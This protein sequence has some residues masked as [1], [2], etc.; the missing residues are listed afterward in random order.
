MQKRL[1]TLLVLSSIA[2][3]TSIGW[4]QEKREIKADQRFEKYE[5][6]NAIEIYEKAVEKGFK[7]VNTLQKLGDAYYFNGKLVEANKWYQELFQFANESQEAIGSEY[8]YRYAQTLR[9]M[10]QYDQADA[11]MAKFTAM[12]QSDSRAQLFEANKTNYRADIE[13]RSNRYEVAA[14]ELNSAFSDYG[15]T[16]Y[17]GQ[18]IYTSARNSAEVSGNKVH[19]WTNEAYTSLYA[20]TINNDGSFDDPQLFFKQEDQTINQSTAVFTK[21]G[22]TVY[23]TQNAT[24]IKDDVQQNRYK[25]ALLQLFKSIRMEDGTWSKPVALTIND[26]KAN[27]AHPALTPD[28]KWMYFVSDRSGSIG[29][30]DLFRVEILA[31]ESFGKVENVGKQI[32]TEGRETFPFIS[33]DYM[34]YFSTD[35]RPGLGGLDIFMAKINVDGSFGT[36]T[37]IGEPMN[38]PAD[39]FGY[40]FDP[41][42]KKGFVSS[43]RIGGTGGDDIYFV[44]EKKEIVCKQSIDGWVFNASTRESLAG[45]KITLYD[46]TYTVLDS[47]HADD[48]GKFA[49]ADLDCGKK[50][51]LKAEATGFQTKEIAQTMSFELGTVN[52]V[53]IGLEP[54]QETITEDDDL[55]KKLKLQPI[56]FDFDKANIRPDAAAELAKVVEVLKLYPNISIDVCSHTDSRGNDA[57][58]M[59]LSD[60]RAKSTMKWMI[61]QG[62]DPDRLTGRGYGESQLINSCTNGVPCSKEQHQEN[63]RSEFI[64]VKM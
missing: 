56:Y 23:F 5:Y 8:Y 28:D 53:E 59:K 46:A 38:S 34:L 37:N 6:I 14:L 57:Y 21:D 64:I 26:P 15:A 39:D 13:K 42:A 10:Q 12:E 55:F 58:N 2:F 40:Y 25:N 60:R 44:Q 35:G 29:Q 47:I 32:N 33:S 7:S 27:N 11:Y 48:Q 18:L 36:V 9:A 3:T 45:S 24:A 43:N 62:I 30:S 50:Y 61:D 22:N 20:S 54:V 1:I 17:K 16:I 19:K 63:R 4:A 31:D 51:R 41:K 49:L 52:K